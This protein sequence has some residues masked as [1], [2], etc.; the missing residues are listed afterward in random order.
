MAKT[1]GGS[2]EAAG[3]RRRL[4]EYRRK[5]DFSKTAE[6]SGDAAPP[7]PPRG[8][9]R[10][11]IQKH[12]AS[13]LHFD[14]R[15]EL[16]GV[17]KSWAVPKGPSVDPGVKRLAMEVEDHPISY[18]TFEG[19]IPA[20]QY[21]GGTVM[22]WDRG[23]YSHVDGDTDDL[24]EGYRKG[25]LDIVFHG[26]RLRG[27]F[28][29]VRTARGDDKRQWLLIK[30][31]G[32]GA[33]PDRDI[34]AEE[35]TSIDTGRTMDE[36]ATGKSRVWQSNR[37]ERAD[38][39]VT[40]RST[41]KQA[42]ARAKKATKKTSAARKTSSAAAPKPHPRS[43]VRA[44]PDKRLALGALEPMYASLGTDI[45]PGDGWT[46]EPKLDG[47]RILAFV[48]ADAVSLVTRNGL[49]KTKQFPEV[50]AALGRLA[51]KPEEAVVL[52]GEVVALAGAGDDPA[53]FQ[54]LQARMHAKNSADIERHMDDVPAAFVA[55]DILLDGEDALLGEPWTTR[56]KRLER[57]LRR[58]VSRQ[59]Q[60]CDSS[61]DG[62]ALMREARRRRWEGIIA[63][64]VTSRYA[65]GARSR[66]WLKLK[67]EHR[68]ELVVGGFT[69]PRN[70]RQ[71]LGALLLGYYD[72]DDFIYAGHT[73][74]GFNREGLAAMYRR[75]A[76]LEQPRS[77]FTTTPKTNERAHW[78]QPKVVVEVKFAEWTADGKL[79]Q[80]IYLGTR[81]DKDP[82]EIIREGE[83]V[84][85]PSDRS[86]AGRAM[87]KAS[88]GAAKKGRGDAVKTAKSG[89]VKKASAGA[90]K[91]RS[92]RKTA[93]KKA[94][95]GKATKS[96]SKTGRAK[97]GRTGTSKKSAAKKAGAKKTGAKPRRAAKK[98]GAPEATDARG[99]KASAKQPNARAGGSARG[100]VASGNSIVEQLDE[101][102]GAGG[103]G[104]L[105]FPDGGTLD[106]SSLGKVFFPKDRFTKGD[107]MRYYA[108]VAP[109]I[110]PA[111]ADRPLV[112]RR[113]PN[114]IDRQAF[115][116]QNA[117]PSAPAG[118][119]VETIISD[120]G[121]EQ[122]RYVGGDLLTLLHTVQLGAVSMDPWH[123]R[124]Q[125]ID[126]PD[127]TIIDLDPG[128]KTTFQRVVDVAR[129]AKDEIDALGLRASIK[130]SGSSGLHI[131]IPL[132]TDIPTE[133]ALLI[134]QV[135]A[136][137]V[138]DRHPD[139][140]SIERMVKKRPVGTVYVDY[141][142][143]IRGKTVAGVYCVRA[144][145][146]ATVST[147]LDWDELTADLDPRDFTIETAPERF[148]ER[149]DVWGTAMSRA[150]SLKKVLAS[151]NK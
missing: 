50:V 149:G 121:E 47:I 61:G 102:Q 124:V 83:S 137:R 57:R 49:D 130:T 143:N 103:E 125:S 58:K 15:L 41:R 118:V 132:P 78:V 2:R 21:G 135:V 141:L 48:A 97:K 42:S 30:R 39:A 76:P 52:D 98:A 54:V 72:G 20:G 112:L 51:K 1:G 82:R 22:L 33:D 55:F 94:N 106:V 114:G 70:S 31:S 4:A 9:L 93:G 74:G 53:R 26:E 131:Y 29:L 24:R 113:F 37:A 14:L 66:D 129:W 17:M 92:A 86:R 88:R 46:F 35:V 87:K 77:P 151:A 138:A 8:T 28:A 120:A 90:A 139:E 25:K 34:V 11:V 6:P 99:T 146:G 19:T 44:V 122:E 80:P 85:D 67:I 91:K 148:A 147:P 96:S 136:S 27:A 36:I 68:Q 71:H 59:L 123:A 40:A 117:S 43:G 12:A 89:A 18:N 56:R 140:A 100:L 109:F 145:P 115:Y 81:D 7:A 63:K 119:R 64:K 10:F 101:L 23:T 126:T 142:Q 73:G 111:M 95:T 134:A 65:P 60:L 13:H 116:Q 128:P 127:Y 107:L 69:E 75:L 110:L 84:Q 150:S 62:D 105:T 104:T 45:P 32:E 5:R 16:D 144:K 108:R 3:P 79:R 38:S 133:A